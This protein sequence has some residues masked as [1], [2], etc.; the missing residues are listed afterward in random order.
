MSQ[1]TK[2]VGIKHT[3]DP[4]YLG[5]VSGSDSYSGNPTTIAKW[6]CDG[7]RTRFNQHRSNRCR[8]D[9]E[10][11]LVP[12]GGDPIDI[13]DSEAR[14]QYSYLS[15]MPSMVIQA[16][17]RKEKEE[18]FSA[19]KRKKSSGG[20]MPRFKSRKT[21]D[22]YFV[23]WQRG[24]TLSKSGR[25]TCVLTIRGQNPSGKRVSGH[26]LR[27]SLKIRVR[28]TMDIRDY[29]SVVVNITKGTV[30]FVNSP[31]PIDRAKLKGDNLIVG[32]DRG[33]VVP[34][35]TSD[36]EKRTLD[37][38]KLLLWEKRK[39][40][41]QK[42]MGK[43]RSRANSRGGKTAMHSVMRGGKYQHHKNEA[44]KYS[45]KIARYKNGWC[46]QVTSDIVSTYGTIVVEN[47]DIK[48]M[49]KNG[50]T[51]KRGMNRSFLSAS[52]STIVQMLE[53]KSLLNGRR[54]VY[55]PPQYTSQRYPECGYT[56]RNNRESQATFLC[57]NCGH[58]DNADVNAAVNI[59]QLYEFLLQG[60]DLPA[61]D[62]VND[63]G[64][65]VKPTV[66][67][68][69]IDQFYRGNLDDAAD[70]QLFHSGLESSMES[71]IPRL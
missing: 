6:L 65:V 33:G 53:Y 18:W 50:G 34:V 26:G 67:K 17:E 66:P 49:T 21:C 24:T 7:Y 2:I 54:L 15:A 58:A 47:L 19:A 48:S 8:Y 3:G 16:T 41:H 9:S 4:V 57:V 70:H 43:A 32:C 10:G 44:L 29:T 71:G 23:S 63:G 5:V 13:K 31:A 37:R 28:S 51:R 61:H 45:Q 55:I 35:A 27:W 30:V 11:N 20:T 46:H 40:F 60:T 39:K 56:H 42:K 52:P 62:S 68:G 38:G 25:K 36:G 59:K 22:M 12:I 14:K 64:E 1:K 69:M